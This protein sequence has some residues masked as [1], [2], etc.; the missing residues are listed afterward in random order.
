MQARYI[1]FDNYT[2]LKAAEERGAIKVMLWRTAEGARSAIYLNMTV[3]DPVYRELFRDVR[4]RR[5]L[6]LAINRHEINQVVFYGLATEGN[7]TVLPDSPLFKP[8]Y[9]TAWAEF[10]LNKANRL[11]DEIGLIKRENGVRLMSDGRPLVIIVE[12]AGE[13]TEETDILQLVSDSWAQV[14]VSLYSKP[15]QREVFRNRVY[16]GEALATI[17]S[18][19]GNALVDASMSPAQLA[20]VRQDGLQ[21]ARWGQFYETKGRSGQAPELPVAQELVELYEAWQKSM[22]DETRKKIWHEMLSLNADQVLSLGIVANVPQPIAIN[23]RLRNLPD[24]GLYSWDPSAYYGIYHPD[25]F[26][27]EPD[28]KS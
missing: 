27:F 7:N 5:A 3:N 24:Q 8:E 12:T 26:W 10:D 6:S 20:P 15:L 14:G 21:W 9:Q 25:S 2:F 16:A 1:R 22:D 23:P 19:I 13:S 17:W 28:E 18:G 4:F 11:L